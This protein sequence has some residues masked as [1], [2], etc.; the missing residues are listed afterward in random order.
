MAPERGARRRGGGEYAGEMPWEALGGGDGVSRGSCRRR[1]GGGGE[2]ELARAA[3]TSSAGSLVGKPEG[4]AAPMIARE[5]SSRT[6]PESA[7][8]EV[9]PEL[10][11][12]PELRS[13]LTWVTRMGGRGVQYAADPNGPG[14]RR[15]REAVGNAAE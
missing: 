13:L 2:G 14:E 12:E 11:L 15:G 3:S 7:A 8:A 6:I 9:P 4:P 1:C 5:T 10:E